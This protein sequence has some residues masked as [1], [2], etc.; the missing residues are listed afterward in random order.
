MAIEFNRFGQFNYNV[1]V[2]KE[3]T[4]KA[5]EAKDEEVKEITKNTS[6]FKG[7]ENETD[8]LTQTAQNIYG[9]QIAKYSAQDKTMAD[10]TN[11]ILAALG[12]GNYKVSPEQVASV[13]NGVNT[14]VLPGLKLAEDGAVAAH[15][16]DPNG[17]FAEL[18]A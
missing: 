14:V 1:I 6:A 4:K 8:L 10:E 5:Q 9:V 18:F 13:A 17:P 12:Y 15:I 7:L 11:E 16:A 2:G 3:A